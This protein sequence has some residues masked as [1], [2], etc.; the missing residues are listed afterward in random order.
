MAAALGEAAAEASACGYAGTGGIAATGCRGVTA[1]AN[2]AAKAIAPP[3]AVIV[4][5]GDD[6]G[7]ES[8]VAVGALLLGALLVR[9]IGAEA[10]IDYVVLF[11]DAPLHLGLAAAGEEGECGCGEEW[12]GDLG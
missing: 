12:G 7:D 4:A 9:E 10:V 1:S 5:I 11:V 3:A 8:A 2:Y 6:D